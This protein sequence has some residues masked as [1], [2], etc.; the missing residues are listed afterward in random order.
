MRLEVCATKMSK[1]SDNVV[2]FV[3]FQAQDAPKPVLGQS[4]APDIAGGAYDAAKTV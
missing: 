1:I 2:M 4:S 3:F